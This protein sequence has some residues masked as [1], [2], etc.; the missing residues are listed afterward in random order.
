MAKL[1]VEFGQAGGAGGSGTCALRR[2]GIRTPIQALRDSAKRLLTCHWERASPG[3]SGDLRRRVLRR[4]MRGGLPDVGGD[5]VGLGGGVAYDAGVED[6]LEVFGFPAWGSGDAGD[7][8]VVF[9]GGAIVFGR[10]GPLAVAILI[11]IQVIHSIGVCTMK[12]RVDPLF[13]KSL[14]ML[15][16]YDGASPTAVQVPQV[17]FSGKL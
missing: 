5:E 16:E 15:A 8:A 9:G 7:A 1:A 6:E 14:Y 4:W 2:S 3:V 12:N 10:I 11:Q 13:L 17:Y